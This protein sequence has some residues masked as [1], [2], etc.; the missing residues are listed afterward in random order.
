[1][2]VYNGFDFIEPRRR[3][4]A[5]TKQREKAKL[6][7]FAAIPAVAHDRLKPLAKLRATERRF[8]DK[9]HALLLGAQLQ[10]GATW[11]EPTYKGGRG[12]LWVKIALRELKERIGQRAG[13]LRFA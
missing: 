7:R 6:A 9:A 10:P 3:V 11:T 2:T 4:F 13:A 5:F 1:M 8:H 12:G